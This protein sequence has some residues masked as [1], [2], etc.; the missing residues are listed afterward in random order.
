M[1]ASYTRSQSFTNAQVSPKKTTLNP[2]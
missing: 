1:A 2:T